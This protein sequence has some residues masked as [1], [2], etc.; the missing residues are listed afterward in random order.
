MLG[1]GLV[2]PSGQPIGITLEFYPRLYTL[3][4]DWYQQFT[5]H[6]S[7]DFLLSPHIQRSQQ[8]LIYSS[9]GDKTCNGS[10]REVT[11][12]PSVRGDKL[13]TLRSNCWVLIC[14]C[15]P[16]SDTNTK[17]GPGQVSHLS[18]Y[19]SCQH[20]S[21]TRPY[22]PP[23][24]KVTWKVNLSLTVQI[25]CQWFRN[26]RKYL[27]IFWEDRWWSSLLIIDDNLAWFL[28]CFNFSIDTFRL[29]TRPGTRTWQ[30]TSLI[31]PQVENS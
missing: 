20:Q 14:Q 15:R 6:F 30:L 26:F 13:H 29:M 19:S 21:Q 23:V 7:Q 3:I 28:T 5:K 2:R 22:I 18:S 17:P 8:F 24:D 16:L 1:W 31:D 4:A 25:L 11:P 9:L 10:D 27:A 12:P